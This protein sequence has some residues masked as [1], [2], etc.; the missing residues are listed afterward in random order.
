M[1]EELFGHLRPRGDGLV[2]T[3]YQACKSLAIFGTVA[4]GR[5]D[6]SSLFGGVQDTPEEQNA[7]CAIVHDGE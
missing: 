7:S 1:R 2:H 3:A 6:F 4:T 5:I